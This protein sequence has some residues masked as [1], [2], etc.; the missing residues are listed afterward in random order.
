VSLDRVKIISVEPYTPPA[1]TGRRA[2]MGNSRLTRVRVHVYGVS[3]LRGLDIRM[4]QRGF[5]MDGL[6]LKMSRDFQVFV[7]RKRMVSNL[8][9][10]DY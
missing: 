4:R 10:A 5:P 9:R 7:R 3:T 8:D 2:R 1:K 6:H